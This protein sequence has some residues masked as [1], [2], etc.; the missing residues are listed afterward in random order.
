MG[1]AAAGVLSRQEEFEVQ[2]GTEGMKRSLNADL[3]CQRCSE[4]TSC[5]VG[6][7]TT[8]LRGMQ[9]LP[10]IFSRYQAGQHVID[11]NEP[12]T[13]LRVVCKGTVLE[14]SWNEAGQECGLRLVGVG[15]L[16][17]ATD[18][19][20][21]ASH[22]SVSV[23]VLAKATI[24]FLKGDEVQKQLASSPTFSR[25]L[26]VQISRQMRSL[27]EQ[28]GRL[29][30][31]SACERMIDL[32][33]TLAMLG[34]E[35]SQTGVAFPAPLERAVLA[36][37]VGTTPETVSRLLTRFRKTGLVRISQSKMFFPSL[38]RLEEATCCQS[39]ARASL[40]RQ[41]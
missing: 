10:V 36:S 8:S 20:L 41:G 27:E 19:L 14:C 24:A 11:Q 2:R 28:Y 29:A 32:L 39:S 37:M 25:M 5:A 18:T 17:A 23:R 16:V 30:H 7:L 1:R 35:P 4:S 21:C 12:T 13:G 33:R 3:P 38:K 9:S 34:G 6:S 31:N 26:L 15:G 40:D 22:Y